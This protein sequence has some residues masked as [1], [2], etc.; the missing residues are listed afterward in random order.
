[1]RWR[2]CGQFLFRQLSAISPKAI[3]ALGSTAAKALLGGKDGVT[4]LR[5]K[6]AQV[7][8]YSADGDVSP[9]LS[10]APL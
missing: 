1:M 3:C 6:L 2:T 9:F 7:E 4:K 10:A 5:G 8:R